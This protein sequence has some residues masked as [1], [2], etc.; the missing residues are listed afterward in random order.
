MRIKVLSIGRLARLA[1]LIWLAL[2]PACRPAPVQQEAGALRVLAVESFLADMAQNVAGDRLL[3]ETLAP[4][5]LDP[6]SFEPAPQDVA[7]I[8]NSQALIVNGFGFEKWLQETLDNAGGQRVVITASAGLVSRQPGATELIEADEGHETGEAHD[9]EEGD[10]H[11]W[12]DPV[13]ALAYVENIRAGLSQADPAGREV[14]AANAAAYSAEL[15][16]LDSFIAQQMA[17][18]PPQHR[19][20][21][22]NH[23]SLGYF[24]DRYGLQIVGAIIPS[25]SSGSSPSAQ[26]MAQLIERIKQTGV[27]AIFLE[28]GADAKLARQIAQET[29]VVVVSDLYTH[30][31]TPPDGPAPTYVQMMRH[32]AQ[33]IARALAGD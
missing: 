27:R 6:H 16:A 4:L 24:A 2:L 23:E 26:Q 22:T 32:N 33:T 30:S 17:P 31:I 10:P 14:Y 25:V 21:V 29:G 9:H 1:G 18:I 20:I 12:L 28:T 7:R 11:F 13:Q 8:A 19:Q 15:R 5:G 3:I